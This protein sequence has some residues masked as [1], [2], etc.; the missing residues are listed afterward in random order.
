MVEMVE[1]AAILHQA[2]PRSFVIPGEI[3]RGPATFDGL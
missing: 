3:G 2:G 1:T